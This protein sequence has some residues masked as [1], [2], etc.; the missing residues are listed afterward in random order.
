MTDQEP[1][2]IPDFDPT[3]RWARLLTHGAAV[4]L[5]LALILVGYGGWVI[6]HGAGCLA[7]PPPCAPPGLLTRD[8][9]RQLWLPVA[10][11][12]AAILWGV[13]SLIRRR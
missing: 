13:A 5:G 1:L 10:L 4:C 9:L 12:V 8:A 7:A 11:G 6:S 2:K 3:P